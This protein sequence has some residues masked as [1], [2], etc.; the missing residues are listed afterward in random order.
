MLEINEL[1]FGEFLIL[2]LLSRRD[3]NVCR[4]I[5]I[6]L[7]RPVRFLWFMQALDY[8]IFRRVVG[9]VCTQIPD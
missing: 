3:F 8:I 2:S 7:S 6:G 5:N 4:I 9:H 1:H